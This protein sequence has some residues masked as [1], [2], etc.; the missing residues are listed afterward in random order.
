MICE[1]L[2]CLLVILKAVRGWKRKS[3][4]L[5]SGKEIIAVL[6]R[7]SVVYFL[8]YVPVPRNVR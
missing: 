1:S 7:D 6:I 5:D 8:V 4:L 3:N 2:L